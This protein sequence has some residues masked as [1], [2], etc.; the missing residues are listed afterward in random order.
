MRPTSRPTYGGNPGRDGRG[1]FRATVGRTSPVPSSVP[2][3]GANVVGFLDGEV[4]ED[5]FRRLCGSSRPTAAFMSR[6]LPFRIS[7]K[8]DV[9]IT[10]KRPFPNDSLR[11]LSFRRSVRRFPSGT[12]YVR[13]GDLFCSAAAVPP[14]ERGFP[15]RPSISR[16][17]SPG[18]SR[19][20]ECRT[21]GRF[22][23]A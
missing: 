7:E 2:L 14:C 22:R 13:R 9:P 10:A 23:R 8:T 4:Q 21:R 18:R 17:P 3:S 1:A 6:T 12:A 11:C 19:R 16:G 5:A 15:R 20:A